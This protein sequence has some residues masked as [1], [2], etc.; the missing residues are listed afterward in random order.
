MTLFFI[1]E[2]TGIEPHAGSK[3]RLDVIHI[4]KDMHWKPLHTHRRFG[5]DFLHKI[6]SVPIIIADWYNISNYV[7]S[8]DI[9]LIQYP[10]DMYLKISMF[11][12]PF[13]RKIKNEG[14]KIILLIH[15]LESLRGYTDS[16]ENLFLPLSDAIIVHNSIMSDYVR[17]KYELTIPIISLDIF[18]YL[19]P[20]NEY[21]A[22]SKG[23]DIA[24][25]L[26]VNKSSYV[27]LL[28]KN[29]PN[30]QFNLYGPNFDFSRPEKIWYRGSFPSDVLHKV[31]HGKFGLVWD[32]DSV[33]TC[34]GS[35]GEYLRVNN[36]HKLSLYIASGRPVIIWNEAAEASF[37]KKEGVGLTVSSISEAL[38]MV[39]TISVQ[40]YN[41]MMHNARRVGQNLRNGYYTTRAINSVLDSFGEEK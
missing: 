2:D 29:F 28:Q 40:E 4:L 41:A 5:G 3:A 17:N 34:S 35:H 16:V 15:D 10:L 22:C 27:Y 24:G 30:Y 31:L 8:G 14:V 20:D 6:A 12:I 1:C 32:G 26:D 21:S 7:K 19:I 33:A 39:N 18:D 25:N 38:K 11:S 36:P 37:V 9:L 13:I 23:I